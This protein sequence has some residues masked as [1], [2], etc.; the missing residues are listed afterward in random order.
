MNRS[1]VAQ[2][3]LQ[4]QKAQVLVVGDL[5]LDEYVLGAASRLSPEAP[6]PVVEVGE[7]R[8]VPGGA[9]N[10][11]KNAARLGAQTLLVGVIGADQDGERLQASLQ[12][13]SNLTTQLIVDPDRPTTKKTRVVA[14]GHQVVRFDHEV[15]RGLSAK[16][17]AQVVAQVERHLA[18]V[19]RALV[20]SDYQKGVLCPEVLRPAIDGARA[21]G[22]PC[23]VDPK[24]KDL[25]AYRGAT[26][27]TPNLAEAC[28]AVGAEL[29]IPTRQLLGPLLRALAG[30]SVLVTEGEAGMTLQVPGDDPVHLPARLRPGFDR[31]GAGAT[32][33]AVLSAALAAGIGLK[34]AAELANVAAGV[35][36]SKPGVVAV[37]P[38]ELLA[39]FD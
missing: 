35:A 9:A 6:V 25:S 36:V 31:T 7:I 39:E 37:E 2:A 26:V 27:V 12:K 8:L 5:I 3:L 30:A 20:L 1:Q 19:Q 15:R 13:Q 24:L 18:E 29:G 23:V 4:I 34:E 22:L 16:V 14:S 10:V 21:R 33:V 32:V 11:A 17:A 28:A 38:E